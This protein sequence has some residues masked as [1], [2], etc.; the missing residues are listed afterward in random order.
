MKVASAAP[1][2]SSASAGKSATP[3]SAPTMNRQTAKR[4]MV[5]MSAGRRRTR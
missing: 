2:A 5:R 3:A 1:A 4:S